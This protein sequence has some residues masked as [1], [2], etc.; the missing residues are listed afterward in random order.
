MDEKGRPQGEALAD[1]TREQNSNLRRL[2]DGVGTL[3]ATSRE[4]LKRLQPVDDRKS[5]GMNDAAD[6]KAL[7][8]RDSGDTPGDT[9]PEKK[10]T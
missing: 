1:A 9:P 2:I 8:Q 5:A 6:G 7:G 3:I 10:E 4:L